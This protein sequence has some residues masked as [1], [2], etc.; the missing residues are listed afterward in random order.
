MQ[1]RLTS[2]L[3]IYVSYL[4]CTHSR[5]LYLFLHSPQTAPIP[6]IPKLAHPC[7]ILASSVHA[8]V[9]FREFGWSLWRFACHFHSGLLF[10]PSRVV[11][12][13]VAA[14]A[15]QCRT[16]I[17]HCYY[18]STKVQMGLACYLLSTACLL[19]STACLLLPAACLLLSIAYRLP[20]ATIA[21]YPL[22]YY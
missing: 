1:G 18:I 2:M 8:P 5:M 4:L 21:T 13:G 17:L 14:I 9:Y 6:H 22:A 16:R 11:S 3:R 10:P 19:L 7:A 12:K 20:L 15:D